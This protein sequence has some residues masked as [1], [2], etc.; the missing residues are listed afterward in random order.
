MLW[1]CWISKRNIK[2]LFV[3][4]TV[5]LSVSSFAGKSDVYENEINILE[6][7]L[8]IAYL[9]FYDAILA[10]PY[11]GPVLYD[12]SINGIITAHSC[13]AFF[14]FLSFFSFGHT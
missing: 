9:L 13:M 12:A 1:L 3:S 14:I 2:R 10:K 11:S 8:G 4:P 6:I 5:P 7:V